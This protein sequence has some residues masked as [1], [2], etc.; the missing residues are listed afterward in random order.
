MSKPGLTTAQSEPL[1]AIADYQRA[2]GKELAFTHYAGRIQASRTVSGDPIAATQASIAEVSQMVFAVWYER[3]YVV[4]VE[5]A[6]GS[7]TTTRDF[8]LTQEALDYVERMR[9]PKLIRGFLDML[10]DWKSD[11]RT[12]ILAMVFTIITNV[13]LNLLGLLR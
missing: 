9:K 11:L 6:S 7:G 10:D 13:A 4:P 1:L 8:V 12:A 5:S 2:K 3:G